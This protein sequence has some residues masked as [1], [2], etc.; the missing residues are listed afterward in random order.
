MKTA[1]I[2]SVI[3]LVSSGAVAIHVHSEKLPVA[4]RANVLSLA[5]ISS[6]SQ[7]IRD[8]GRRCDSLRRSIDRKRSD[9]I[10][11]E[12]SPLQD[13]HIVELKNRLKNEIEDSKRLLEQQLQRLRDKEIKESA[14]IMQVSS[15]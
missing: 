5:T 7:D 12:L 9:L 1:T 3:A 8:L 11:V 10:R 14:L 6:I 2:L 4:N 13:D 15:A